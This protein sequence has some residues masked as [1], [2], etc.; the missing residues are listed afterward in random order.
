MISLFKILLTIF[1]EKCMDQNKVT[2]LLK[3]EDFVKKILAMDE[4]KDVQAAFKAEGA[5]IS[6]DDVKA[7]GK[8]IDAAVSGKELS[9]DDLEDVAG[10]ALKIKPPFITDRQY[11][12]IL[13]KLS[14]SIEKPYWLK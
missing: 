12:D 14:P 4:P 5:E 2:A 10:G 11:F 3:N 8:V 7:L 13:K 6:V 1:K 9:D